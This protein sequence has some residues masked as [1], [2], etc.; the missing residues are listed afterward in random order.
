MIPIFLPFGIIMGE[1]VWMWIE[2]KDLSIRILLSIECV[3]VALFSLIRIFTT[4]PVSGHTLILF[5]YLPHEVISNRLQFPIRVLSGLIVLSITFYYKIF[6]WNDPIT[7]FLG[8]IV[9]III[10][11]PGYVYRSRSLR[12]VHPKVQSI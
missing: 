10:W 1:S 7:F 12:E 5:F 11:I 2:Q 8:L 9:G 6:I 3:I 4:I